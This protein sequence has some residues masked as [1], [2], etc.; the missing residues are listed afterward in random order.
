MA[1]FSKSD[2]EF[3]LKQIFI[4]EAHADGASLI[5]LLPNSQVP[6]GLRTVDGSFNNL[7]AGQSE[8]GASDN[9]FLRLLDASYRA[10]YVGTGNVVDSQPRTI[11][12]LIVDQTANN[13]AAVEAN[14]GAAP[15]MS[16]GIDG[17]FG[18][19]DDKPV[20]F[21]PNVSPDVG[22]TA[23]FNAWMTFFGQFFD[24]GLDLV[25][26]SSTDIVF[27]PLR[28]DDPLFVAGSPTNFMVLSRAVRTA[29]ADG[30]VGTA[31]DSQPNTTSPFVDQSQTYSSHP[32]HQVFLREY[33]LN[34]AG[35][36]V[37]TGRLI[38]NRDLGADGKFGTADDGNSENG[39]MAT[40]AVVKAQARDMLGI[41]LTDADVHSVPLLA[42][43][44]YGNFLR[45]PNGMPQVVM[46]VNNGA[47]GIAG[48]ADDVTQLV[49]GD[50]N[51]PISLANA[52]STGHGFLDDIAHN[53]AP[54]V[55]GG[56][57][58]ADADTAVGNAQPVGPG[59]NNLT[60][61]N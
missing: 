42:T 56:V 51:A 5:D 17:V 38:T 44:A 9:A 26:K 37:A 43:D 4:A 61:D 30:V 57:L 46:R 59:G 10:N 39:G 13:P 27:I 25:S 40:W 18:T 6:F 33:A 22:L 15:V 8:F 53:A 60:Y 16:P 21:I 34:A 31:D 54:V 35:D 19:A 12:N 32:S 1:N 50:R 2:L 29:G 55:V 7:V 14:G 23:G 20:F 3:I 45:G 36:P 48:T 47:D 28:P 52:V 58:Q 24:H 11:S 41:N 49:E